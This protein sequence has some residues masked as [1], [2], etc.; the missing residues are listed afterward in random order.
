M[1]V[2]A[3]KEGVGRAVGL[4]GGSGCQ[5]AEE[6]PLPDC[7]A[8]APG[9]GGRRWRLPQPAW[10]E[11]SSAWLW[12]PATGT[13]WMDLEASLLPTGPNTSNTSDGPDNLTSAGE[14]TGSPPSSGLWVE[15]GKVSPLS[16]TAWETLSQFLG[17][18]SVVYFAQRG[19]GEGGK[20]PQGQTGRSRAGDEGMFR[21]A[22]K[23]GQPRG[24]RGSSRLGSKE[25]WQKKFQAGKASERS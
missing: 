6:D 7:G 18:R 8:C 24:S 4:G 1:S 12:E 16:Q 9:Q 17:T 13:G 15:N 22:R 3:A 21:M 10:V 20:G 5:A 19:R 14:L 2:R 25:A 11:G 23:W